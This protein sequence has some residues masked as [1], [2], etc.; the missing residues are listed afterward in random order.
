LSRIGRPLDLSDAMRKN[1]SL[2]VFSAN[3]WYDPA[4]PFLGAEHDL[5][6]LMLPA[7]QTGN[8]KFGHYPAGYMVYLNGDA[9]RDMHAELEKWHSENSRTH[10]HHTG[11]NT[12]TCA[13]LRK[14]RP[15]HGLK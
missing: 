10:S 12:P 8:V 2:R 7:S 1:P 4:T 14:E 5:G 13:P 15:M 3:G 9:L 11:P 6:Q